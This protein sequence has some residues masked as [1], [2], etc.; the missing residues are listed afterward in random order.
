MIE[1]YKKA[2]KY[3]CLLIV[4]TL[5]AGA[6]CAF[7]FYGRDELLP[8]NKSPVP[9]HIKT[10]QDRPADGDGGSSIKVLNQADQIEFEYTLNS[11]DEFPY[12][13]LLMV[14]PQ[15]DSPFN[16][17][18]FSHYHKVSFAVK[19][20]PDNVATFNLRTYDPQ[21]TKAGDYDSYRYASHWF[22][23]SN[24]WIDEQANLEGLEV[25]LWWL[26][27]NGIGA[28]DRSY[29]LDRVFALSF[30]SS[31]H[32]S[33]GVPAR[34]A[35]A[36]ITLHHYQWEYLIVFVLFCSCAW[37]SFWVWAFK[38]HSTH[39]ANDIRAKIVHDKPLVAYQKLSITSHKDKE[40][41]AVLEYLAKHY[42]NP[43]LNMELLIQELGVNSKKVNE[44]LR[45]EIGFTFKAYLNKLRLTE[46]ARL[47]CDEPKA[48]IN[49]VAFSV[50]YKNV[51]HFNKLFKE[52]F[53]CAPNKFKKLNLTA[54]TV[55]DDE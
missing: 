2:A 30:D 19:C 15:A 13:K 21:A 52:E 33:V 41:R 35:I 1:F 49:E 16:T 48:S 17:M 32:G 39:L 18:N 37:I 34:I 36:K 54:H 5:L 23:C 24:R 44:I 11:V 40:K 22:D 3:F 9:W 8:F 31:K 6:L 12:V 43:E 38:L 51:T 26:V 10:I 29:Q 50:G 4:I 42:A 20:S 27:A 25:P 46:A 47:V 45:E 7:M 28:H 53:G 14:F 55:T